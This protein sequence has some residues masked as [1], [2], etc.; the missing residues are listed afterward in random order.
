MTVMI[1]KAIFL[2]ANHRGPGVALNVNR[3][4]GHEI[5]VAVADERHHTILWKVI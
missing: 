4:R 5:M 3:T 1:V 2:A